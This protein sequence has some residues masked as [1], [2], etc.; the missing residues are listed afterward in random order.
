MAAIAAAVGVPLATGAAVL[1][2]SSGSSASAGSA[3]PGSSPSGPSASSGS[4]AAPAVASCTAEA[5]PTLGGP[6]GNATAAAPNGD[7]VGIAS[8]TA[9]ALQAVE[10]RAGKAQRISTGLAGSVPTDINSHGDVVGSSPNGVNTVGWAW[11]GQQTVRLRGAGERTALP[12]AIS[13]SG[14]IAG[15]LETTE[16]TPGEG[17]GKPGT[18]EN[19]QAAVWRSPASAPQMLA[20]LPGEQGAHAFAAGDDGRIGGVS[21]GDVFRPVVWDRAGTPHPLPGLG[22]GYGIV[23]AFGPGGVAVGDAVA[24]DGTD[25][26]VM[27]DAGGQITDLGLPAGSRTAQATGVLPGGVAV[28]TARMPAPGGGVLTQ[29]VRWPAAGQ[30]Q[31]L[32]GQGPDVVAASGQAAV[33]YR[34]DAKGGRHPLMWR[35]GS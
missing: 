21:E 32:A 7:V 8:D 33:G 28:G 31:L 5:L 27:W 23:R 29:A 30:P 4:A 3:A 17:N 26:A 9:G 20:P 13:N 18:Q 24:N 10:W 19:E 15:A 11:S 1:A 22:G 14:V 2:A 6:Y 12:A 16:G 25:H 34:T 35:C